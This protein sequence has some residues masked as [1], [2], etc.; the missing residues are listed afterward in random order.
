MPN[1]SHATKVL[2][3]PVDKFFAQL[4]GNSKTIPKSQRRYS[5]FQGSLVGLYHNGGLL[6][7]DDDFDVVMEEGDSRKLRNL[8]EAG[9]VRHDIGS[10][11]YP[12]SIAVTFTLQSN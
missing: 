1:L 12:D 2:D 10:L 6:P 3:H 9:A 4:S 8:A 11:S 7:W 5:I